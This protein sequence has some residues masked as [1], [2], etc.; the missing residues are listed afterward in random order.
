MISYTRP[1]T[2]VIFLR[3]QENLLEDLDRYV[4]EKGFKSRQEVIKELLREKLKEG[5]N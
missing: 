5:G 1:K 2:K 3:L 4:I